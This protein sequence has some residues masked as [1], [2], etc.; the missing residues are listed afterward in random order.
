M[1][2]GCNVGCGAPTPT[3][4]LV[5]LAEQILILSLSDNYITVKAFIVNY[6]YAVVI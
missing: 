3:V 2:S 1:T 5:L 6:I 4:L